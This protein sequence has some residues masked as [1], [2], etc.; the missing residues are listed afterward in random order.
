MRLTDCMP[1]CD[2]KH[3][4]ELQS[5]REILRRVEI[6]GEILYRS[7]CWSMRIRITE[8]G[9][10]FFRKRGKLGWAMRHDA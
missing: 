9:R 10:A 3:G 1:V 4:D 8:N 7:R 6:I 2:G 5:M